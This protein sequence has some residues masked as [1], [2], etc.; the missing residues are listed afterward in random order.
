MCVDSPNVSEHL[1]FAR[2]DVG[3]C[4]FD[5]EQKWSCHHAQAVGALCWGVVPSHFTKYLDVLSNAL[6]IHLLCA[7]QCL[8]VILNFDGHE[9][10][11]S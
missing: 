4:R 2:C 10:S 5:T 7:L 9:L 3:S 6:L 8:G 11:S 1:L